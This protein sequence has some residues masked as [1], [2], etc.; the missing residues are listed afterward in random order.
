MEVEDPDLVP[1]ADESNE[2][3][4]EEFM[5]DE[6]DYS[7]AATRYSIDT[8]LPHYEEV[9]STNQPNRANS[10]NLKKTKVEK[11]HTEILDVLQNIDKSIFAIS[12]SLGNIANSLKILA[13]SK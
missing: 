7:E 12:V 10:S 1:E 2:I 11:M 9:N 5:L 6:H 4:I 3:I 13:E 8:E